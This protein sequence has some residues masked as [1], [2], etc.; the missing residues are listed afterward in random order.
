[1]IHYSQSALDGLDKWCLL[2][3]CG[4]LMQFKIYGVL[5]FIFL[6]ICLLRADSSLPTVLK[7]TLVVV[8]GDFYLSKLIKISCLM[9]I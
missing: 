2:T 7:T 9:P 4:F 6:L 8:E 5:V 1:M 3:E